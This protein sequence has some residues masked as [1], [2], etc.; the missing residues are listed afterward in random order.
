MNISKLKQFEFNPED[1]S[2]S[3]IERLPRKYKPCEQKGCDNLIV[4][5]ENSKFCIDPE[6]IKKRNEERKQNKRKNYH[7][8][9]VYP[10]TINI[11]IPK[12]EN[13]VGRTL[14]LRCSAKGPNGR[15]TNNI[16]VP[17]MLNRRTYP[18]FCE[19]HR[20]EWRRKLFELGRI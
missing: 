6:C 15:C 11:Q 14:N 10:S 13:L 2:W 9:K 5:R 19:E 20:N 8:S 17:Y 3:K 7:E 16:V 12:R 1:A 18:K 4:D